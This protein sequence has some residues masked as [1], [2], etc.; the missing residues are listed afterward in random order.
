MAQRITSAT[1]IARTGA[2][3]MA[4]IL[5]NAGTPITVATI[6]S[7]SAAVRDLDYNAV[8]YG[9][10][11]L[12]VASVVFNSYVQNDLRWFEAGGDALG[13]NFLWVVPAIA[14]GMAGLRM[15]ADVKFVPVSGE[16]F[17]V[18]FEGSL[19]PVYIP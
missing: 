2:V 7:I 19:V 3:L 1:M 15:R 6:S 5:G 8:T 10:S 16:N 17:V 11:A 4:R 13:Y 18:P 9:P 12:T 14:L